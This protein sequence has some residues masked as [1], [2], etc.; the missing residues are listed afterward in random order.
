MKIL[1]AEDDSVSRRLLFLTLS[2]WGY[3]VIAAPD[4]DA[5]WQILE[6]PNAPSMAILDW[7][8]PGMDGVQ[9]CRALRQRKDKPYVYLLLLTAKDRTQDFIEGL[10]AGADDYLVKPFDSCELKARLNVGRRIVELQYQLLS[11]CDRMRDQAKRDSLT[12]LCNHGAILEILEREVNRVEA[13]NKFLGVIMA[14][15]DHFKKIN[16]TF[17]HQAGD[18]V[19]RTLSRELTHII[20]DRDS[21]GR[22]G[23]EEFLLVF[24]GCEPNEL[25]NLA[26]RLRKHIALTEIDVGGKRLQVTISIGATLVTGQ[27]DNHINSIIKEADDALYSAKKAGRNQVKLCNGLAGHWALTLL[28]EASA[29]TLDPVS[30]VS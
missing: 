7:M 26:E 13:S 3:E 19:L 30:L 18:A 21:V 6:E 24:P 10:E 23:G 15:I 1:V 11:T 17:G 2:K 8:M 20:R 12:G 27:N 29:S 25:I 16:D 14:D 28:A 4:G 9:V 5:A 22:Y